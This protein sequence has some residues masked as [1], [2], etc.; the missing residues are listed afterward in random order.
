MKLPQY[1]TKEKI[2]RACKNLKLSD[3]TKIKT[4]KISL[5]EAKIVLKQIDSAG[6]K[7]DLE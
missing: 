5:K 2:R 4:S 6:L 3:W 7:I 1:V